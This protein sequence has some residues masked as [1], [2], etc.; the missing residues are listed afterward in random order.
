[1]NATATRNIALVQRFLEA[2]NG[3]DFATIGELLHPEITYVLP[4]APAAFPRET[5]GHAAVM[6][7]LRS[8]PDFAAEE[9]LHDIRIDAFAHDADELVAEFRSDMKLTSGRPYRNTYVARVTVR[10][11]RIVRFAEHF[12]PIALVE[13]LGGSVTL[14]TA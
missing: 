9:N 2:L 7:F 1:M 11:G 10:D 6:A 14:P 8:V 12:D 13:A 5:R 4:Y 3:W